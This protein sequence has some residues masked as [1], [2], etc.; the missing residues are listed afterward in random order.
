MKTDN[1]V[2]LWL[3]DL[4]QE[5]CASVGT[6]NPATTLNSLRVHDLNGD[7]FIADGSAGKLL[8]LSANGRLEKRCRPPPAG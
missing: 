5:S 8:K 6:E 2:I 7:L 4:T 3:C 1:K